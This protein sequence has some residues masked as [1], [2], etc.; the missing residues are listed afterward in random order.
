MKLSLGKLRLSRRLAAL[1]VSIGVSAAV[2]VTASP[3]MAVIPPPPPGGWCYYENYYVTGN[4]GQVHKPMF[5]KH[6]YNQTSETATWNESMTVSETHS[7]TYEFGG[8]VE[9]GFDLWLIKSKIEAHLN[10]TIYQSKTITKTTGFTTTVPPFSTKYADYGT[11]GY[12][13]TG[14]YRKERYECGT[15][16][17]FTRWDVPVTVFSMTSEGWRLYTG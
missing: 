15:Y 17:Y 3:A 14:T 11:V 7:S 10:V 5:T 1:A 16:D 8:S 12:A 2:L 9:G 6:F 4:Q 13:T